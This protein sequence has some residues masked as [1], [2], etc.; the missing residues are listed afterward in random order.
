LKWQENAN[1]CRKRNF[2]TSE[3]AGRCTHGTTHFKKGHKHLLFER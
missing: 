1:S 2:K 3:S